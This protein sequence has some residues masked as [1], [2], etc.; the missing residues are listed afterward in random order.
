MATDRLATPPRNR[1]TLL[2]RSVRDW[3]GMQVSGLQFVAQ[4]QQK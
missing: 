2:R 3:N 4:P 1:T